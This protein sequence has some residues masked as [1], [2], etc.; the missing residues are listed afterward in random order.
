MLE[1]CGKKEKNR[2][3]EVG[4]FFSVRLGVFEYLK[5]GWLG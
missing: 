1:N 4:M 2:V 5:W 3:E